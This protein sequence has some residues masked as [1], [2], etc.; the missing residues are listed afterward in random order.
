MICEGVSSKVPMAAPP[1]VLVLY[2]NPWDRVQLERE[3]YRDC[4]DFAFLGDDLFKFPESVKLVA[5]DSLGFIDDVAQ[6]IEDE[7]FAG[8]MSTDEYIGA[9]MAAAAAQRTRR[10]GNLPELIIAAQHKYYSREAQRRVAPEITPRTTLVPLR[11]VAEC[12]LAL[13]FPFFVKP[14]KGTFSLFAARVNDRDALVRHMG[15]NVFERLLLG[16]VTKPFNDLVHEFTDFAYDANYFIGEELIEG[17]Q[18]TVDGFVWD[19]DVEV[20]GIVD[21]VMF[22]GTNIFERFEYPSRLPP[23]V[24]ERMA[25]LTRE[26]MRGLG[27]RHGQFNVELFYDR[28]HD[29][30]AVIEINPRM[31]YQFADLYEYVD[32]SNSYD[33]LIDLTLG[34][35]PRFVKGGGRFRFAASFVL[36]T[37][38]GKRVAKVPSSAEVEAFSDH[39]DEATIKLYGKPGQ[40]MRGEMKAIG[41]YRH[42]IVNVAANSLLDLFAIHEDA[43]EKLPFEFA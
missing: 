25:A 28:P 40:S 5:Y 32:G 42:A 35:R 20:M 11:D 8:V 12:E 3:V 15:F 9:I 19:G 26:V 22:E 16:R 31:S 2:A 37:F 39:Y 10:P 14:V 41:S 30:I 24:Q 6:R 18:V 33:V 17:D 43:L 13:P 4:I 38:A 1:R 7:G 27:W 34:R 21:S 29:R 36:R 23:A